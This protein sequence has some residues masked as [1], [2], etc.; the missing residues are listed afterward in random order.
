M[1]TRLIV[2]GLTSALLSVPWGVW[3]LRQAYRKAG[4]RHPIFNR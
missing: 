3:R 2:A 1:V 4:V